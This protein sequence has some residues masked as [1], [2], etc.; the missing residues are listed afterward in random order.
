MIIF[1]KIQEIKVFMGKIR[2][3]SGTEK[4]FLEFKFSIQ[5][6]DLIKTFSCDIF[7]ARIKLI[8]CFYVNYEF[9]AFQA[10]FRSQNSKLRMKVQKNNSENDRF[11]MSTSDSIE[12]LYN[13]IKPYIKFFCSKNNPLHASTT[14]YQFITK[15]PVHV[16]QKFFK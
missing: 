5:D 3:F 12:S 15:A 10:K 11:F 13:H 9:I 1:I 4:F 6:H 16:F 14:K 2:S 8:K 7:K